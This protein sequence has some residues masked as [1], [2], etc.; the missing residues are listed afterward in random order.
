M[1]EY[2]VPYYFFYLISV[3]ISLHAFRPLHKRFFPIAISGDERFEDTSPYPMLTSYPLVPTSTR[4][5]SVQ[6]ILT[7]RIRSHPLIVRV[8][9]VPVDRRFGR[10]LDAVL[11]CI[12][13]P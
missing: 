11:F 8:Y 10:L 3:A 1:L 7:I 5:F 6:E 13:I 2:Q 12:P 9:M 4:L